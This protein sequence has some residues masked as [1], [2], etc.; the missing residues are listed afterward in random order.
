MA[1]GKKDP[2]SI[3]IHKRGRCYEFRVSHD[4]VRYEESTGTPEPAE[5]KEYARRRYAEI[6][7]GKGRTPIRLHA[8]ASTTILDAGA[9][10][11]A[12]IECDDGPYF[13]YLRHWQR[14]FVTLRG[15]CKAG[16]IAPYWRKR[17]GEVPWK[18]VNKELGPLRKFLCWCETKKLISA[19]PEVP[20]LPTKR[21]KANRGTRHP[22]G[23]NCQG[24]WVS[25][26]QARA[27]IDAMPKFSSSKR[28][29]Q[30]VTVR[31]N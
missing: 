30:F 18:T 25:R 15:L 27:L 3:R 28:L 1:R 7:C 9:L 10:W 23:R 17:L 24:V 21:R 22:R 6:I 13:V 12:E 4:G 31:P 29:G 20:D 26:D 11:L 19:A 5:A 2:W 8:K 16:V 14:E